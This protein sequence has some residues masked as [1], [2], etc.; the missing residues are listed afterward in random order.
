M[1]KPLLDPIPAVDELLFLPL[2]GVGEIGMNLA[3]YG[4]DGAW[5]M[6]DLGITFAGEG[7]PDYDVLMADPGFIERHRRRLAG[8][9]LTHAHEDHVGALP[10]LWR[11]LRCP[12]YATPF[13]AAVAS[14]KLAAAGIDRVPLTEVA[15]GARFAVG[16]F[17][18]ELV[19]VTHSI[20]EPNGILIRTPVGALYHTGD[21]K[22]DEDPRLGRP[23]DRSRLQSLASEPVLAMVCDSTNAVVEGH[24]GSEG[25]LRTGLREAIEGC[26]GRVLV[27]SFSSNIAR[28]ATVAR[29]AV[30]TGRR[31]GVLG[32]AMQRMLGFAR[33]TGYWPQDLP[34][35]VDARHLALLPPEEVLAACTGS[36]GEPTAVLSRL[37]TDS[38]RDLMLDPGDTVIF[39]SRVIP[40]NEAAV[41]RIQ[42]R[43]RAIGV[44]VLTDHDHLVHVSGHPAREELEQLYRWVQP[45]VAIPVHG[46]PR[47][48]AANAAIARGC[49]VPR[50]LEVRNGDVCR[51]TR[52]G[53]A[54]GAEIVGQV[55]TGR[56]A[57][58]E[59]GLEPVS[60]PILAAMRENGR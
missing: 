16:P 2:G 19:T 3:L 54:A 34:E 15:L 30:D 35:L 7:F 18:V 38:H 42:T 41:E 60:A 49:G 24:S 33:H 40:G 28:L 45:P 47:H 56:L 53:A 37:A 27:G 21:W 52:T 4:H 10:Y 6:V 55:A 29:V 17:D 13:T 22:L 12:V 32:P 23:Y 57:A 25:S 11:R 51:L 43:L 46:T 36:Q 31:F 1:P 39:S 8:L 20:P 58:R 59:H 50:Q 5:L 9:V 48:L 44:R 26:T 14:H